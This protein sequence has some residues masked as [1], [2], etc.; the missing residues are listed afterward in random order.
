MINF[1]DLDS[2]LINDM[3]QIITSYIPSKEIMNSNLLSLSR[4]LL[5]V[6]DSEPL[7]LFQYSSLAPYHGSYS[8]EKYTIKTIQM[9]NQ[10]NSN[11]LLTK[12]DNVEIKFSKYTQLELNSFVFYGL[13]NFAS[14]NSLTFQRSKLTVFRLGRDN[15]FITFGEL[16]RQFN[17]MLSEYNKESIFTKVQELITS[18]F[19]PSNSL[20]RIKCL[21]YF[22]NTFSKDLD[23]YFFYPGQYRYDISRTFPVEEITKKY[24]IKYQRNV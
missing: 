12:K 23:L 19:R 6:P 18:Y 1:S 4:S 15:E 21:T 13:K 9:D 8:E 24:R 10:F 5:C 22:V 7:K 17:S 20:E 11:S 3:I 14:I 16:V 2:F